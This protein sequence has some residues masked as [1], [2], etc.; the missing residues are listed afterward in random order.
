M[1]LVAL[2]D[3]GSVGRSL[4][5]VDHSA[6]QPG[7]RHGHDLLAGVE[8]I[9]YHDELIIVHRV[10]RGALLL[11]D[12]PVLRESGAAHQAHGQEGK[13]QG[14]GVELKHQDI[15]RIVLIGQLAG[16]NGGAEPAGH[17]GIAGVGGIAVDIGLDAALTD[18]HVPIAAR[19]AGPDGEI[20]LTLTQDLID[21]SVGLAVGGEA[22][23][24]D[25]VS[26]LHVF[27]HGFGERTNFSHK[28]ASIS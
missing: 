6:V 11:A 26:A 22:A 28:I 2:N 17:I 8:R 14:G 10:H 20:F 21:R 9:V 15:L 27:G 5:H 4:L 18:H 13:T 16:L 25:G 1:E 3:A 19:R 12:A 7:H 23:K 24:A